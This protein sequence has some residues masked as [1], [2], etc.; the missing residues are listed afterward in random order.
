MDLGED[1]SR[2]NKEHYWWIG[3]EVQDRG[4]G[5]LWDGGVGRRCRE[6]V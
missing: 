2:E 6:E 5:E 3:E 1:S 4:S